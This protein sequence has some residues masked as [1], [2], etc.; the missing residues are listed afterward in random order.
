M[1]DY[2]QGMCEMGED[3]IAYLYVDYKRHSEQNAVLVAS[4]LLKQILCQYPSSPKPALELFKKFQEKKAL[5]QWSTI[6][7][8]LIE[9]CSDNRNGKHFIV[10]DA[11]DEYDKGEDRGEML[12]L[13]R[14]LRKANVRLFA[15][16]RPF[17]D[18]IMNCFTGAS[19]VE[20]GASESDLVG[21][22]EGKIH[23]ATQLR[24]V[25]K[26]K[27]VKEI[28]N[29]IVEKAQ[30]MYV[31]LWQYDFPL[32]QS[33]SNR[34]RLTGDLGFSLRLCRSTMSSAKP[35]LMKYGKR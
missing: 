15:T 13:I 21:Y 25:M 8:I 32:F 16:S 19:T 17:P 1:I 35:P 29:T 3:K 6:R 22:I 33:N 23:E 28:T 10:I 9:T 5:P 7:S 4:C 30:G 12:K 34:P 14:E 2:L 11:L 27:L 20:V 31:Y 18:D 24:A 26:K